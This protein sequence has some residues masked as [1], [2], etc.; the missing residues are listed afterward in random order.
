MCVTRCYGLL[1]SGY[2]SKFLFYFYTLIGHLS[3]QWNF[4]M[5]WSTS[6]AVDDVHKWYPE[7]VKWRSMESRLKCTASLNREWLATHMVLGKQWLAPHVVFG[8]K[9]HVTKAFT[10]HLR[11]A[12][13]CLYCFWMTASSPMA[14]RQRRARKRWDADT[15]ASSLRARFSR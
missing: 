14:R 11:C 3:M 13:P 6:P 4:W 2:E 5:M 9:Q 8:T 10:T 15:L 7:P 12:I 1:Q